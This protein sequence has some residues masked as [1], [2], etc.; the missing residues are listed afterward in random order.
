MFSE[1]IDVVDGAG[2]EARPSPVARRPSPGPGRG[3]AGRGAGGVFRYSL[4]R[5]REV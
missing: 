4:A 5:S 2:K 1:E 3:R